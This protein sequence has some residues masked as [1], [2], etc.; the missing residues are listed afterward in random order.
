MAI[1][2]GRSVLGLIMT[3]EFNVAPVTVTVFTLVVPYIKVVASEIEKLPL[4]ILVSIVPEV[5]NWN[6]PSTSSAAVGLAV[7]IPSL[8]VDST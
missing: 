8:L 5:P 7:P 6:V 4:I 1:A 3:V 2:P